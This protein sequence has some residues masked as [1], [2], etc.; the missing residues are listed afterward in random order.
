MR[1][2]YLPGTFRGHE[3]PSPRLRRLR[4]QMRGNTRARIRRNAR[5][6]VERRDLLCCIVFSFSS[7]SFPWWSL[8]SSDGA[9]G[10]SPQP[11]ANCIGRPQIR[12]HASVHR[13][14]ES[15]LTR[16]YDFVNLYRHMWHRRKIFVCFVQCAVMFSSHAFHYSYCEF[17]DSRPCVPQAAAAIWTSLRICIRKYGFSP[18]KPGYPEEMQAFLRI[19]RHACSFL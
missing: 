11:A 8:G 12:R 17:S 6:F 1:D 14:V 7:L 13:I 16:L 3:C 9:A 19:S 2:R 5:I 15:S 18:E 10:P 4:T